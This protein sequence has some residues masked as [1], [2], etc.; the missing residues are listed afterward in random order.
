MSTKPNRANLSRNTQQ[1]YEQLVASINGIVWE[2]DTRTFQFTFVNQQAERLLGYPLE[3]WLTP[4]FWMDHLHPDDRDWVLEFYLRAM[5]EKRNHDFEYRMITA[6]G[7]TVW[8]RDLVSVVVEGDEV[9]K[10][11][12]IMVDITDH[13]RAEEALRER[14]KL[15]RAVVEQIAEGIAVYDAETRRVLESNAAFQNLLG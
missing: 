13:K 10:L 7:R 12:G 15:Y 1:Q 6:D 8:L 5:R 4:G 9:T 3:Q 14:E 11:C 2:V